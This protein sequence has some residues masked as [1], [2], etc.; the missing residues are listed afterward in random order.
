MSDYKM[1]LFECV[2]LFK[3]LISTSTGVIY[4]TQLPS[5]F[6]ALTTDKANKQI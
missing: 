3:L 2:C 5:L 1:Y 4:K 6:V